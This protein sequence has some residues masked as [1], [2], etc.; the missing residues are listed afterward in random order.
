MSLR[1]ISSAKI[2][3]NLREHML[4]NQFTPSFWYSLS[5][6]VGFIKKGM[7]CS[8]ACLS[9]MPNVTDIIEQSQSNIYKNSSE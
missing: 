9:E 5:F 7:P 6:S 2:P 1:T 4:T 8:W 3:F